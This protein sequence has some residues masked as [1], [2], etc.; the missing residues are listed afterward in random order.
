MTLAETVRLALRSFHPLRK[1]RM[2]PL[3][4]L[5]ILIDPVQHSIRGFL[6]C[7]LALLRLDGQ[8]L[9]GPVPFDGTSHGGLRRPGRLDVA[10]GR[11]TS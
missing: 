2:M 10:A 4:S 9:R 1:L 11:E 3:G 6:L 7:S 5:Q 8:P